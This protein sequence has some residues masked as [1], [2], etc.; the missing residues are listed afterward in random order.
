MALMGIVG[1]LSRHAGELAGAAIR[2][3]APALSRAA[4]SHADNTN[5]F[6]KEARR[7]RDRRRPE[8][9]L[10]HVAAAIAQP[11][12]GPAAPAAPMPRHT[13][14]DVSLADCAAAWPAEPEPAPAGAG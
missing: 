14:L 10:W 4:S 12:P 1:G 8:C 7:G 9:L 11:P 6:L 2:A 3:A 13:W 5:T